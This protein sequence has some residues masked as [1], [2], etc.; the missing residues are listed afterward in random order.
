MTLLSGHFDAIQARSS[1][2]VLPPSFSPPYTL[3]FDPL[4]RWPSVAQGEPVPGEVADPH[5]PTF[6]QRYGYGLKP[7]LKCRLLA[8]AASHLTFPDA[9]LPVPALSITPLSITLL[10][11]LTPPLR[12]IT[13]ISLIPCLLF[14]A[15]FPKTDRFSSL[16]PARLEILESGYRDHLLRHVHFLA[17]QGYMLQNQTEAT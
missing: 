9:S 17:Y 10:H 14:F 8:L 16:P 5:N 1:V 13:L 11:P 4:A 15:S 6:L 7:F 12:A 3:D 2:P